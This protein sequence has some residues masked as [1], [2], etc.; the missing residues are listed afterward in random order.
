MIC[1][2]MPYVFFPSCVS[3]PDFSF[4]WATVQCGLGYVGELFVVSD[5]C[6]GVQTVPCHLGSDQNHPRLNLPNLSMVIRSRKLKVQSR[7]HRGRSRRSKYIHSFCGSSG[8][9]L[10]HVRELWW[11]AHRRCPWIVGETLRKHQP[12][13]GNAGGKEW[14][15]TGSVREFWTLLTSCVYKMIGPV[16]NPYKMDRCVFYCF[17]PFFT[18][19]QRFSSNLRTLR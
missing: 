16:R 7:K 14:K 13:G 5:A 9:T 19:V 8:E 3:R 15:S 4:V 18:R 2:I 12:H 10:L 17:L 6:S 11:D 1:L